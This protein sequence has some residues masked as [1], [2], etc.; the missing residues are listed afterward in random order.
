MAAI[1]Q[2]YQGTTMKLIR[3]ILT[4]TTLAALTACSSNRP[5][6]QEA[7]Q[8][9]AATFTHA[10][11]G[12]MTVVSFRDFALTG[13]HEAEKQVS[14]VVCDVGGSVVVDLAGTQQVRPFV[15]PVRFSRASGSWTAHKP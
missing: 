13:C 8:A 14:D 12:A 6:D 1:G 15:E 7:Q 3:S 2:H 4:L 10:S 11:N 9:I 5:T